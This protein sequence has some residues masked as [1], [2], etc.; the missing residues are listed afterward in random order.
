[1][2][3]EIVTFNNS[4]KKFTIS[5]LKVL[6]VFYVCESCFSVINNVLSKTII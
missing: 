4:V 6:S 5:L 3:F 1:M 2:V